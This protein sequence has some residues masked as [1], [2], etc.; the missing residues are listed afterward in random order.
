MSSRRTRLAGAVAR[1]I[2]HKCDNM[3]ESISDLE[4]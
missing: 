2:C 3:K 1:P 4:S